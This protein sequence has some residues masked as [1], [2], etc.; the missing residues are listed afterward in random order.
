MTGKVKILKSE[1][2]N[3]LFDIEIIDNQHLKFLEIHNNII[4]LLSKNKENLIEKDI[5]NVINEL[6]DYVKVHFKTEE[7]LLLLANYPDIEKHIKEHIYFID[8][9]D[10]FNMALKY[11]NPALLDNMLVF[12]KKWFLSHIKQTDSKYTEVLKEYLKAHSA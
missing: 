4:T 6:T 2:Q 7:D 3:Y 8:K 1:L 9:I 12:M 5:E 11:K 10:E